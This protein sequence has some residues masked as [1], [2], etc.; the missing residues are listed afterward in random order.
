M[1]R[2]TRGLNPSLTKVGVVDRQVLQTLFELGQRTGRPLV[3]ELV[4]LF[5]A[6]GDTQILLMRRALVADDRVA[7]AQAAHAF[8]ASAGNVGARALSDIC[9]EIEREAHSQSLAALKDRVE[10]MA[11]EFSL[12]LT[13]LDAYLAAKAA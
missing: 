9:Q 13:D 4:D 11:S 12:S 2:P 3:A 7:I 1:S 6:D 5:R 8:K 10:V